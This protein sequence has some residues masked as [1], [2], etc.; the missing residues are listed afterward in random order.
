[1]RNFLT[2]LKAGVESVLAWF[3][4]IFGTATAVKQVASLVTK[5]A[6]KIAAKISSAAGKV[7]AYFKGAGF[8]LSPICALQSANLSFVVG[9]GM[10][11]LILLAIYGIGSVAIQV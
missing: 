10:T 11:A 9:V 1:M 2:R 6:P 8:A 5:T 3:T 4:K 7:C